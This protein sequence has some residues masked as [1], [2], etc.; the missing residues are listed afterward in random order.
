M[1]FLPLDEPCQKLARFRLLRIP[2]DL[3][4]RSILADHAVPRRVHR[5]PPQIDRHTVPPYRP[6]SGRVCD[7]S[8]T[9]R[10]ETA[11]VGRHATGFDSFHALIIHEC[12][13]I[14]QTGYRVKSTGC[15]FGQ[16]FGRTA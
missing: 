16:G 13:F 7:E 14:P 1:F 10:I 2:K 4:R 9:Q 5:I 12:P 6:I 8:R 11:C 15:R 3:L